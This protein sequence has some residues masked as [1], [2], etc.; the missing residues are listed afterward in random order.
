[1][2][3]TYTLIT[4]AASGFG[5]SIA[6]KLA[7]TRKL[8]LADIN[9]EGLKATRNSCAP[10]ERHQL[11]V[12]DLSRLEGIGD[13]LGAFLT[14]NNI[15]VDHFVHSAGIFGIQFVTCHRND[16]GKPAF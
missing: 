5:R 14:K 7:P 2:D 6:R 13:D 3:E 8:L 10:P 15:H 1:M 12:R 11:W 16:L 4:G 9:A